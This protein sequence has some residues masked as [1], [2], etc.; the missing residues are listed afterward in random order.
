[1]TTDDKGP[2]D[3]II[4]VF[5]GDARGDKYVDGPYSEF[6]T[7]GKPIKVWVNGKT[8]ERERVV[9]QPDGWEEP[10]SWV[11][12][13]NARVA[14]LKRCQETRDLEEALA[15]LAGNGCDVGKLTDRQVKIIG[16]SREDTTVDVFARAEVQNRDV[17]TLDHETMGLAALTMGTQAIEMQERHGQQQIVSSQ[18]RLPVKMHKGIDDRDPKEVLEKCGGV[19]FGNREGDSDKAIFYEVTL[20]S[21]WSIQPTDHS[22]WTKLVDDQGRER[23]SIFYKAAFYDRDAFLRLSCRYSTDMFYV[24]E[25]E[26]QPGTEALACRGVVRDGRRIIHVTERCETGAEKKAAFGNEKARAASRAWLFE[27]FPLANDPTA[28]WR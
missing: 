9:M 12:R 5:E 18:A 16:M 22:M 3:R 6:R 24:E 1:M 21:G 13:E 23:A 26:D 11:R 28:Y 17:G 20:P 14:T 2:R 10:P 27:H 25:P 15:L 19:V 7:F 4:T 8:G